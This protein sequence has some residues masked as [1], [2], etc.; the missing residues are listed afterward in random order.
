MRSKALIAALAAMLAIGVAAGIRSGTLARISIG[1]SAQ[2]Q[3]DAHHDHADHEHERRSAAETGHV[4]EAAHTH[5]EHAHDA[6]G[7]DE[8]DHDAHGHG[9]H[10]AVHAVSFTPEQLERLGIQVATATSGTLEAYAEFP[11][12]IRLNEDALTHVAPRVAGIVREVNAT[13][14]DAVRQGDVMAVLESR[15]LADLKAEYLAARERV[16]LRELTYEREIALFDKQLSPE[17]EY[18]D[19]RQA[20]REASI[21]LNAAGQKLRALGFSEDYLQALSNRPDAQLTRYTLIAP[22]DGVVIEKHITRGEV[23]DEASQP[24][25]IADLST[26]WVDLEV[27]QKDL[28]RIREGQQVVISAGEA[29]AP[30]VGQ[31]GYIGP[32]VGEQTRTALARVVLPNPARRWRAGMF[33]TG[34]VAVD[35]VPAPIVVPK[36]A[37]QT[38]ED[39]QVV[40]VRGAE[41]FAPAPVLP[42][43]EDQD[44][45][46]IREG[47]R[48]G[49]Q[50]AATG[51]FTLKAELAKGSFDAHGH[52]H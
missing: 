5:E 13:L 27:Y 29:T 44:E 18:L 28:P 52:A 9:A 35:A 42:G 48:A 24:F 38:M 8:H 20:V 50:Y 19:A 51:A 47:L 30:A 33:V 17:Q 14:G 15:D 46:E 21:E 39:A 3:E 26:V 11:G 16:A 10:E 43:R 32:I 31:I 12:E 49:Q 4:H 45:V 25:T 41:G 37:I 23:L 36:T 22:A 1:F 7:H 40:F 34:R 6:H 2:A